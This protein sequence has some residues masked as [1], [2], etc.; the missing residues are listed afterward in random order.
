MKAFAKLFCIVLA[1]ISVVVIFTACQEPTSYTVVWK[2]F[3]GT[4]LETDANLSLGDV[5]SYDGQTPERP[6]DYEYT[7][8]F[9]GW[10][11]EISEVT[12]DAEYTAWYGITLIDHQGTITWKNYDGTVLMVETDTIYNAYTPYH[13]FYLTENDMDPFIPEKPADAESENYYFCGWEASYQ[14]EGVTYTAEF[15]VNS[16]KL[17]LPK[18]ISA[19]SF[20][21]NILAQVRKY[22]NETS[23]VIISDGTVRNENGNLVLKN[24]DIWTD[25]S[26][27][28]GKA[29]KH[30][31]LVQMHNPDFKWDGELDMKYDNFEVKKIA[32]YYARRDASRAEDA[33]KANEIIAE[34]PITAEMPIYVFDPSA[35]IYESLQIEVRIKNYLPSYTFEQLEEDHKLVKYDEWYDEWYDNWLIQYEEWL[36]QG[37]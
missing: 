33:E 31:D 12:G 28:I 27:E 22:I 17:L 37:K 24:T 19:E 4:V 35:S 23:M 26:L 13:G 2:N 32:A 36:N 20:E 34:F 21:K 15:S 8:E 29:Y 9:I 14:D 5:V 7:Y 30:Y 25:P 16:P 18:A 11:K 10:D 1:M 6:A 3:D